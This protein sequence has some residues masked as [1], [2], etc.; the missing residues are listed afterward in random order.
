MSKNGSSREQMNVS[1]PVDVIAHVDQQ[2][3]RKGLSR[4]RRTLAALCVFECLSV[5]QRESLTEWAWAMERG[6]AAWSDLLA[7]A[8][9][10]K[11]GLLD[12]KKLDRALQMCID[13]QS[14]PQERRPAS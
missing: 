6:V 11:A 4:S 3:A 1:L 14:E 7:Y 8:Q 10:G 9:A 13:Q 2:E 12:Q 5:Q